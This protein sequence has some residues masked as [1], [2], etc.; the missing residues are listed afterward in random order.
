MG[1]LRSPNVG[2]T[3]SSTRQAACWWCFLFGA[4]AWPF[5]NLSVGPDTYAQLLAPVAFNQL[6][7]SAD[8]LVVWQGTSLVT[9]PVRACSMR[10]HYTWILPTCSVAQRSAGL[11]DPQPC[12]LSR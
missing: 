10:S 7:L 9:L 11:V 5:A 6:R 12:T 8:T 3:R 4:G 2:Q 1:I